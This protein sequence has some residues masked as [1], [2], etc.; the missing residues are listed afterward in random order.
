MNQKVV[1]IA[2]PTFL[3]WAGWFDLMDQA[4]VLIALDDVGFSKHSWQQR[5]RIRTPE[6]LAYISVPVRTAGRLGQR[7][8]DA[9]LAD[10]RFVS[11][12][13]RTIMQNYRRAA[14]FDRYFPELCRILQ[15]AA[16]S[17]KLCE[18]NCALNDWLSGC[19]GIDTPR[20]RASALP[21]EGKRGDYIAK[22]CEYV[23]AT[24]YLSTAGAEGYLLQ[25]RAAFDRRH[26]SVELHVYEHPAYQQCFQPFIP[27]ASVIDLLFNEGE[28]AASIL[29]SG[30][31]PG[32]QLGV[33][34][35]ADEAI[36][37]IQGQ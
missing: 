14:N 30:R 36:G 9:E 32:R 24:R 28:K 37:G 7:I 29:R 5:N 13:P 4:D 8:L 22:L 10:S 16:S 26:I 23:G 18:L 20:L 12:L 35:P 31:R 19:L 1:A 25:D 15:V 27:Y 21:V 11:K 17:G 3:P 34:T 6:G 2:Q 33:E